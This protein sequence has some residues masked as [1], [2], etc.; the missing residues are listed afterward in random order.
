MTWGGTSQLGD[1]ILEVKLSAFQ[2]GERLIARRRMEGRHL[3]FSF[4]RLMTA[5][6][7]RKVILQRHPQTPYVLPTHKV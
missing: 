3:D 7:F 4:E 2:F 1:F 6:E 5:F